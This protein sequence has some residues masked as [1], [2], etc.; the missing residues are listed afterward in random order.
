MANQDLLLV[1]A[2]RLLDA[3]LDYYGS[4]E[5]IKPFQS[6][7]LADCV[8]HHAAAGGIAAMAAGILPGAGAVA[9]VAI[10]AGAIWRMYIKICQIIGTKFEKNKLKMISSAVLTNLATQLAGGFAI[11]FAASFVPGAGMIAAGAI[12][13]AVTYLAGLIF[14]NTLTRLFK[15]TR[16]DV[17]SM[18]NE[19]WVDSIKQS[20]SS[21][22]KKAALKEAKEIFTSMRKDGSLDRVGKDIDVSM[23]E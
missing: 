17:Q 10:S 4:G 3:L 12:N 20:L 16:H 6:K 1:A 13:F 11:Q 18:T 8:V 23:E 2:D 22:D 19:D 15:V 21:I 5:Y 14:L 7:D 9:A